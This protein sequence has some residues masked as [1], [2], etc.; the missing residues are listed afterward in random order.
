M[1]HVAAIL[2]RRGKVVKVGVNSSKTHPK[3]TRT[4]HDGSSVSYMHAEMSALRFAKPGDELEVMRFKKD[5][6]GMTMA[7]PCLHCH[8]FIEQ[9]G[10]SKVR[11]TNWH[12]KW[13]EMSVSG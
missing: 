8:R 7:K 4:Y 9:C 3:Y 1:Y 10:I 11:Y 6:Y 5:G 2:R 13:E 12:G